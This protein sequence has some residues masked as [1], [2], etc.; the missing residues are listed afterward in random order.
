MLENRVCNVD[1]VFIAG[2]LRGRVL[3][4]L[5][6]STRVCSSETVISSYK[7]FLFSFV[8]VVDVESK[9]NVRHFAVQE[10]TRQSGESRLSMQSTKRRT[11]ML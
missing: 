3:D 8:D 11:W 10:L 4:P 9:R 1:A 2:W 7:Q 5:V 6:A